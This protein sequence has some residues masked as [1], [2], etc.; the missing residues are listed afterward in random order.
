MTLGQSRFRPSRL[1]AEK[2]VKSP[3]R[4]RQSLAEIE[5][6]HIKPQAAVGLQ[7]HQ[8]IED[9]FSIDRLAIRRQTH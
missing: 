5:V 8:A 2:P 4:H 6:I 9:E 3:I 7:I 1:A